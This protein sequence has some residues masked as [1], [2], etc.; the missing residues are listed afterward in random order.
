MISDEGGGGV[1]QFLIFFLHGGEV[2]GKPILIFG[3]Q[4]GEGRSGPP[5]FGW[6]NM[7]TALNPCP[8]IIG[9]W[10]EIIEH[11]KLYMYL[12]MF[13]FVFLHRQYG[14]R[15]LITSSG[16]CFAWPKSSCSC[17][18]SCSCSCLEF[19]LGLLALCPLFLLG[20]DARNSLSPE[21]RTETVN[22]Q[23]SL[24]IWRTKKYN[25]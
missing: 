20:E 3:W 10:L 12:S 8:P 7:W 19:L 4:G 25:N 1:S 11:L 5:I 17:T 6:H 24:A 14:R 15:H 23:S 16:N 18:C 2:G 13:V 9:R 21:T 22:M